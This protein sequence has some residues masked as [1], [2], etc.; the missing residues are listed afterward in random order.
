MLFA[1]PRNIVLTTAT[2]SL[3]AKLPQEEWAALTGWTSL[4]LAMMHEYLR[5]PESPWYAYFQS[6]PGAGTFDSLMFWS[7]EELAQLKGSKVVGEHLR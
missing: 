7:E 5:G 2:A 4:M 3:P 1:I 6:M